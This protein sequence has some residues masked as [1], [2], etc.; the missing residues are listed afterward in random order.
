MRMREKEFTQ[1]E[2]YS[3]LGVTYCS[4]HTNESRAE[5]TTAILDIMPIG[6]PMTARE[7]QEI[8]VAETEKITDAWV[9][10]WH[11]LFNLTPQLIGACMNR[12]KP[13]GVVKIER[14]DCEPFEIETFGYN[15]QG[16]FGR[17]KKIISDATYNV[18]TRIM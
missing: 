11:P 14:H 3:A 17:V 9:R 1:T 8:A 16:K 5:K 12:L 10:Y 4:N 6:K 13:L 15:E 7:I 18:Y 2:M